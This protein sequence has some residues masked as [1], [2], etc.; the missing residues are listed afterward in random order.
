MDLFQFA[1]EQENEQS[2]PLA[3]RM[4]PQSLDEVVGQ[5]HIVGPGSLLRRAIEADR[6]SSVIFFG[7]PGTGKTTLAEVIA[8]STKARFEKLNAVSSGVSDIRNVIQKAQDERSMYGR[9]TVLFIDEIHRFNKSQQDAL[10]PYVESG[11]IILIGAT[12]ENPYFEVNPA[13]VSRSHIFRLNPLSDEDLKGLLYKA[14]A[15]KERG[16]GRL[17]AELTEEAATVIVRY[18]AGDARRALNALELAA[19]S[20]QV[21]AFGRVVIGESEARASIQERRVLYDKSGDEHYDTISAFIK[22]VRGSDPDAA[23]LWLAKMLVAGEDPMFIARRL[24]IL[25]SE[26]VGNADPHALPLAV[27]GMQAVQAIG[28][29]EAR[30]VLAQV[31]TYLA[32]APKS[33]AAYKA[34]NSAIQDVEAGMPLVV[35]T[36]LRGTG[37]SG[38]EKLGSGVGYLYPHD[39]PGHWVKQNY[40]PEGVEPKPY[41]DEQAGPDRGGVLRSHDGK[42]DSR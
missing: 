1:N 40:W 4:R 39:F 38:A 7:P 41:Y 34:I 42:E 6:L 28:M 31:T 35:P 24:I 27:A 17:E 19:L 11:L 12:T 8:K 37:Y 10:L 25:A 23:V 2:A 3:H 20:A 5:A 26:D 36:H 30:I 33:N 9:K 13:L 21:D 15:D 16:L 32:R 14:L 18:A 29:P 22:S